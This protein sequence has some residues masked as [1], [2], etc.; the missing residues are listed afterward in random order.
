MNKYTKI[1]ASIGPKSENREILKN[2]IKNGMNVCRLNFSHDT[3]DVQGNKIDTIRSV[4]KELGKTVAILIDLQGPKHRIGNF[5][6]DERYPIEIGQDFILDNLDIPGDSTRVQLPDLDVLHSL[7]VGDRVLL[8]DG[9]IELKV[10]EILKD[11]IKT[12]VLRGFEIW[13]R[14]G[15]NIPDTNVNTSVLTKKDREDL[16][17]ALTKNPDYV[18]VSFVQT[19]DDILEVRNFIKERTDKPVKIIA[20]IERPSAVEKISEIIDVSD[21][22]MIARGDLAVE[23]SFEKV[24]SISRRIVKECRLKNKPVIMATQMLGSMVK[25][26]FPLRSEI[27]DI[28]NA[29]YL[30]VDSTM[31]S[32]ETTVSENPPLVI[33]TMAKILSYADMDKMNSFYSLCCDCDIE[34]GWSK[35]VVS[36]ATLNNADA[37]VIFANSTDKVF[38]ISCR[39]SNTPIIAICKSEIIANQLCLSRAVFPIFN[40]ESFDKKDIFNPLKNLGLN[41]NKLVIVDGEDVSLKTI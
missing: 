34:N 9:K 8:D 39:R 31:T 32:E 20:K 18:A 21:G 24:P 26:E 15:F 11:S 23:V 25:S 16:T 33:E 6:T 2:M 35:S 22:I 30:P 38:E 7:K 5:K 41:Y 40:K 3:G 27:S 17:Y 37:I 1:T 29:A 28:A 19:A 10:E 36:I 13:S 4:A 14:R 12:K